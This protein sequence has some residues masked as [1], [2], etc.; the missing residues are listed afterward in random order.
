MS[1]RASVSQLV[2]KF[3]NFKNMTTVFCV[4]FLPIDC[5]TNIFFVKQIYKLLLLAHNKIS[6]ANVGVGVGVFEARADGARFVAI[7]FFSF[8]FGFSIDGDASFRPLFWPDLSLRCKR[9][10]EGGA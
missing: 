5:L 7:S 6:L 4:C 9:E 3:V 1:C 8:F 10:R 2:E